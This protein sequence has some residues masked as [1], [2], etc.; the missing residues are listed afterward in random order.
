ME[1]RNRPV[2]NYVI[3]RAEQ[4]KE[5]RR[6]LAH[7]AAVRGTGLTTHTVDGSHLKRN[8]KKELAMER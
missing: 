5:E 1:R 7:L 2:V 6:R 4:D 3:H 8:A